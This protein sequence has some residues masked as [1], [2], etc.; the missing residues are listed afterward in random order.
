MFFKSKAMKK[1]IS[2]NNK[3]KDDIE[4]NEISLNILTK[5]KIELNN[6]IEELKLKRKI[7]E[8]DLKHLIKIREERLEIE[9]EKRKLTADAKHQEEIH[10]VSNEYRTK[11]EKFLIENVEKS[12]RMYSELLVR[13]P[14]V[15]VRLKGDV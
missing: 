3:L 12:E 2:E 14:D 10:K 9:F 15:N 11:V 6:E 4:D 5:Q 1:V 7:E 8:E 13:L